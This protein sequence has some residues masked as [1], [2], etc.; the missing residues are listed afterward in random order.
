[1]ENKVFIKEVAAS[2]GLRLNDLMK[3]MGYASQP[4]FSR[5]INNPETIKVGSLLKFADAIGCDVA[6]LFQDPST[7]AGNGKTVISCPH[8]GK[9]IQINITTKD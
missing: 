5:T 1:M 7:P 2:Y 6:E 9:P 8:C 3:R 4:S